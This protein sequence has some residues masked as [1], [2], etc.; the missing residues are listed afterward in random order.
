MFLRSEERPS[1]GLRP[2]SSQIDPRDWD[3]LSTYWFPIAEVTEL[4]DAP[5]AAKLLDV[6]LVLYR[7]DTGISVA[8]DRCPHRHIK[9]SAGTVNEG[10]ITCPYHALTFNGVGRCTKV[11]A[12][13]RDA[14][15]PSSYQLHTFPAVQR[16]GLV[17]TSLASTDESRIP[18]FPDIPSDGSGI[19]FIQ[20]RTWPCSSARQVENFFDLAHLPVVHSATLGN[21]ATMPVSPGRVV[22]DAESVSLHAEYVERPFGGEERPCRYIY[23]VIL[24]F[25][26]DFTVDDPTGHSMKLYDLAS[27]RSAYECR[28]FQFM[29]DTRHVDE[30]HRQ[31]I[32]GL[33]AVNLEDIGILQ[34]LAMP[35]LPLNQH[36]EIHLQV[37]NIA[38][39]YR[40]RL[41]DLG[42][43]ASHSPV[44]ALPKAQA[45]SGA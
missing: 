22:Q 35:D 28:V 15:L 11:P 37:D 33:D 7:S 38:H 6:D 36:H 34:N 21:D 3:V 12:L 29:K 18:V 9:L 25:A 44:R 32:E 20:T 16:Y 17:W 26:L 5:F 24:P 30:N 14:R 4:G 8:L 41:V 13:G 39:A 27:P 43:G 45:I 1:A 19:C 10:E 2:P 31:L 42:L 23:K 40:Q